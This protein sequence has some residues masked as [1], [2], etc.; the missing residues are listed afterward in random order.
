MCD[1]DEV[2][3]VDATTAAASTLAPQ[4]F[5]RSLCL[6]RFARRDDFVT[7]C[8]MGVAQ[9]SAM[10]LGAAVVHVTVCTL[11]AADFVADTAADTVADIGPARIW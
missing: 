7:D 10:T 3:V 6:Q 8:R 2:L 9:T 1:A 5:V 4:R 11:V